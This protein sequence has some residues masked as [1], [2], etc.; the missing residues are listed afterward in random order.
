MYI[1]S[2]RVIDSIYSEL[3]LLC[4][5]YFVNNVENLFVPTLTPGPSSVKNAM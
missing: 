2:V 1:T 5:D 3:F 4:R